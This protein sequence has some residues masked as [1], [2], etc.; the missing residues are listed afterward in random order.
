VAVVG[1]IASFLATVDRPGHFFTKQWRSFKH[2]PRKD[3]AS[4]HFF[5]LGS[6]RYDFWRVAL[7]EFRDHPVA[8]I[9][10]RGF[11]NAYLVEGRSSET[12]QRAHSLELDVLSETGIVGFVLL[13][14]AGGFV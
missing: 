2:L 5:S 1:G 14:G 6:N 12:P 8:G 3:T 11:Y 13:L 9:G 10:A 4:S 7:D